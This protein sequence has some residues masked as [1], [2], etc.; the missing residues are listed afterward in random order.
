MV[1]SPRQ[2]VSSKKGIS[3]KSEGYAMLKLIDYIKGASAMLIQD[4]V[5]YLRPV[6]PRD[7][8]AIHASVTEPEI[9]YLT[10]THS[11]FTV[12]QV[13]QHIVTCE[14]DDSRIDFAVCLREDDTMIGE[15]GIVEIDVINQL[16]YFRIAMLGMKNTGKGY[17]TRAVLLAVRYVFDVLK[18]NRLQLEVYSHNPHAKRSYEKVGFQVE[19]IL[20]EKLLWDGVYSDEIVMSILRKDYEKKGTAQ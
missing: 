15:G 11:L 16:A 10:G 17:G 12:E 13:R 9:R 7:A 6:T 2:L 5:L 19:G 14:D 1:F 3:P 4:D 18:L 20:R 8:E